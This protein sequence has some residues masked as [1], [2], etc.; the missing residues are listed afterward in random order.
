MIR[1][2]LPRASSHTSVSQW[3]RQRAARAS[4]FGFGTRKAFT[5]LCERLRELLSMGCDQA[6]EIHSMLSAS[7]SRLNTEFGFSLV[8]GV[9]PELDRFLPE[10]DLIERNYVRYLGLKQALKLSEPGFMEQFRRMLVSKLRVVFENASSEL[11]L[12]NRTASAQID[13]QLRE[14]SYA[15][16]IR[17]AMSAAKP[18]DTSRRASCSS[19]TR[20]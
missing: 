19:E 8:L 12:W 3:S 2:K 1:I 18:G 20:S 15:E 10:L 11:E 4:L 6:D 16:A 7:F 13:A 9:G 5:E 17:E 14:M